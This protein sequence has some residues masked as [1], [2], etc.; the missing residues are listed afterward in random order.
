MFEQDERTEPKR[1]SNSLFDIP[2]LSNSQIYQLVPAQTV[3]AIIGEPVNWSVL[4]TQKEVLDWSIDKY[5]HCVTTDIHERCLDIPQHRH[6]LHKY[7]ASHIS[8]HDYAR[9]VGYTHNQIVLL[10]EWNEETAVV[11][12]IAAAFPDSLHLGYV[13]LANP[14][15]PATDPMD[16]EQHYAGLGHGILAGIVANL[17]GFARS[18]GFGRITGYAVDRLR[19]GIFCRKGFELNRDG[20]MFEQAMQL[21]QQIPIVI[22][23]GSA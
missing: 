5:N 2:S 4:R 20:F 18:H 6:P 3:E 13:E 16:E 21:D 8:R 10:G 1:Q 11:L 15:V 23:L 19:A 7:F 17:K 12:Q 22:R 14:H 9:K